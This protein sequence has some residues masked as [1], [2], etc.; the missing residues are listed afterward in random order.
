[1]DR[2]GNTK[3]AIFRE[4]MPENYPYLMKGVNPDIQEY[5]WTRSKENFSEVHK[6]PIIEN[7]R[8]KIKY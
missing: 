5:E 6:V 7:Q 2:W 1:M 8:W 3:E 4:I